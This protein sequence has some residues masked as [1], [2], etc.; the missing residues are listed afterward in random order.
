MSKSHKRENQEVR[1]IGIK[2]KRLDAG[3]TQKELA[4]K[5]G[6]DQSAV[7]LWENGTGPKRCRLADVAYALGCSVDELL[8]PDE[9]ECN[10]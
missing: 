8:E 6:V 10:E 9:Q 2:Q 7:A 1:I 3:M 4:Q 5:V